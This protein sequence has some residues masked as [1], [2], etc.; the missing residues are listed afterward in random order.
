MRALTPTL[1]AAQRSRR[2]RPHVEAVVRDLERGIARLSW[3]RHYTGAEPESHHDIAIDGNGRI[4]R[5]R[6]EGTI[7]YRQRSSGSV[8]PGAFP[9]LFP[10]ALGEPVSMGS[11][12]IVTTGCAGPCAI[13]A[14]GSKVWIF[15]RTTGN[16][17]GYIH[18]SNGG[19][20]W[21]APGTLAAYA[22]VL[23]MAA[24]WWT[25]GTGVNVVCFT[26]RTNEIS[27]I[28]WDTDTDSLVVHRIV[29]YAAPHSHIITNT[30]GIGATYN[31]GEV[32]MDVIFA[33]LREEASYNTYNIFRTQ[34]SPTHHFTALDSLV[35]VP[36]DPLA[37]DLLRHEYPDCHVP[38]APQDHDAHRITLVEKFTGVDPYDRPITSHLVKD[39]SWLDS[40]I[41]EPRP[42]LDVSSEYGI[43]MA[44]TDLY[45]LLS[46]PDGLW[47]S[48]RTPPPPA[49][50]SADV[51]S[52]Q[53]RSH[54]VA[55]AELASGPGTLV[56]ELDN[57]RGQYASLGTGGLTSLRFRAELELELGYQTPAGAE[58]V[59]AG[60]YWIDSWQY[61]SVPLK[62][63][64]R[65]ANTSTLTLYCLD[66]WSLANRWTP[67]YQ[68]RWNHNGAP[69]NVWGILY[70]ILA[71][72]G[73]RLVT[74]QPRSDPMLNFYPDYTLVPGQRGDTAIRRLLAT[75]PDHLVFDGLEAWVKDLDPGET[76]S[77]EYGGPGEHLIE[78]GKYGEAVT[79][80]RTRAIGRDAADNQVIADEIDWSLQQLYDL[81]AVTYDP[82][83]ATHAE[84][85]ARAESLLRSLSLEGRWSEIL[86]PANVGQELLDVVLVTDTRAGQVSEPHRVRNI[87]T[88]YH[89]RAGRFDQA[90]TL[91]AP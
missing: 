68:M 39:T 20:S 15:W 34:L 12:T 3:T 23:S 43:R 65:R 16:V 10:I 62:A 30:Y 53:L 4:H 79:A 46:R 71:R 81:L 21:S 54:V 74:G 69:V 67:R 37:P 56:L 35:V 9:Y 50:L 11:W 82:R 80:S 87:L 36:E 58:T 26:L 44:S 72:I 75:V 41:T 27:A 31:A 85:L 91:G 61:N 13:A 83:L 49:D 17:I 84:A 66:G 64:G 77:Y 48:R 28:A 59:P 6:V 2:R 70:R 38:A 33:G 45:W 22:D 73:I 7:L 57:S 86:V 1:E 25:G 51:M 78:A 19:I 42:F 24:A 52:L 63:A 18:S 14:S 55:S 89:R 8:F 60:R 40:T 90:I 32:R 5:I 88:E 47:Y 76:E 29:T